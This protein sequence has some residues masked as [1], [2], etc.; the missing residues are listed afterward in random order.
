MDV[1]APRTEALLLI[2]QSPGY[3]RFFS[4]SYL[5]SFVR[6]LG[7]L[8]V[9]I[10]TPLLGPTSHQTHHFPTDPSPGFCSHQN[11]RLG[12]RHRVVGRGSQNRALHPP[13]TLTPGPTWAYPC[14]LLLPILALSAPPRHLTT[15]RADLQRA[16]G[17]GTGNCCEALGADPPHL[18]PSR[19]GAP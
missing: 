5:K 10:P 14:C 2:F 15:T 4:F 13:P 9:R 12:T 18:V 8:Q 6:P 1:S 7:G 16:T 11:G 3:Q 19:S 17:E